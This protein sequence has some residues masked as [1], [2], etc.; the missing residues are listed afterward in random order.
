MYLYSSIDNIMM[1]YTR[2]GCNVTICIMVMLNKKQKLT[3]WFIHMH[4]DHFII[5]CQYWI[6]LLMADRRKLCHVPRLTFVYR[7]M[8]CPYHVLK[9]MHTVNTSHS[10]IHIF[11]TNSEGPSLTHLRRWRHY[12]SW[13]SHNW[14]EQE[15]SADPKGVD[16]F[17][18]CLNVNTKVSRLS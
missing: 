18:D 2:L 5:G 16:P 3:S 13:S 10:C 8:Y 4:E 1:V 11:T 15:A 7:H 17:G 9:N 6:K 12:V 14:C